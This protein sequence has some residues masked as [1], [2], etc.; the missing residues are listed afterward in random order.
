ML[1]PFYNKRCINVSITK[2]LFSRVFTW[3]NMQ[4]LELKT[5]K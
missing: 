4:F 1:W 5:G 3:N 2:L